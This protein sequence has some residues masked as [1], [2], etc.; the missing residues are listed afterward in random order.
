VHTETEE[1]IATGQGSEFASH[2]PEQASTS[3]KW[4]S[5]KA[6]FRTE[7]KSGEG[8]IEITR[9]KLQPILAKSN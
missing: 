8:K 3:Q 9:V 4:R 2:E 6:Q 1:A 5:L 7:Q